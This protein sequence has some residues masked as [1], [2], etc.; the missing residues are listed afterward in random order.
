VD[1]LPPKPLKIS[2]APFRFFFKTSRRYSQVKVHHRCRKH[3]WRI[4]ALSLSEQCPFPLVLFSSPTPC[5]IMYL[6]LTLHVSLSPSPYSFS[7]PSLPLPSCPFLIFSPSLFPPFPVPCFHF[8]PS[9]RIPFS[10]LLSTLT[11][12]VLYTV[13]KVSDFPF[14]SRDVT[15]QSPWPGIIKL[16]PARESLV[17]NIPAWDGNIANLFYM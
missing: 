7:H 1:H 8:L 9:P 11:H 13:K 15:N 5:L 4:P 3:L 2:T 10:F 6:S 16:L 17:S 14:P 12:I